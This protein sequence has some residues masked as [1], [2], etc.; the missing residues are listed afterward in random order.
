LIT[1]TKVKLTPDLKVAN[2]YFSIYNND[3]KK[4]DIL[5][6]IIYQRKS[7]R[8]SLGKNLNSKYVPELAFYIDESYEI[9]DN[10]NK[11]IKNG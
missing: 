10:I 6:K 5:K 9:Y 1:V 8:F 3:I 2:V 11:I 4:E 7:I